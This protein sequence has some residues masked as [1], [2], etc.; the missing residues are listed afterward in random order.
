MDPVP[1]PIL[2][3]NFLG[4]SR[5]SN[6]GSLGWQSDVLTTIPNRWSILYDSET[7]SLALREERRLKVFENKLRRKIFRAKRYEI[8]GE[9]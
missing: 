5:E 3:E 6:S 1:D 9:W 7:L 8:T 2:L 4:N